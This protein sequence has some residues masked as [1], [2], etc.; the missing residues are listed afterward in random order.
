MSEAITILRHP[1]PVRQK[2]ALLSIASSDGYLTV[3]EG[4]VRSSKTVLA[5]MAF[6]LYVRSSPET[7]FLMSGRTMGTIEQNCILC[8]FGI[9]N[10]IP[11]ADYHLIGKKWG[12]TFRVKQSDGAVVS[13]VIIVQGASTIKDFMA[14]RGQ[15]YGGWFADEINMHDKEFV[16]EAFKRTAASNDRRHFFTLNP[17][18]PHEWIYTDYLDR[19]DAMTPDER[20][21]LGGYHWWHFTPEDNP[22]M[23]PA[24]LDALKMQYP[25]DSYL[26]RRYILG[27][28]C[29]AEG[30]IYPKVNMSYFRDF[31]PKDVDVRYASIDFGA[32]HATVMMFGGMFKGN[33]MDWRI[34]AEYYDQGSDKTTYDHYLGFLD[35]CGKLGVD[36]NRIVIAIDPAA[37]VLRLEFAKHG[38]HVIKAKNDVLP[39]IDFTRS[40]IYRG[41]LTFHS[42]M[43]HLLQEFGTYSWDPKASERGEEKPIK[44]GDD[45]VDTARYFAYTHIRPMI[46][47]LR[48]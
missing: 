25:A 41:Y 34:V 1:D 44:Q 43:K 35:M 7:R 47:G 8:E 13:K 10:M 32:E 36:P 23:T 16:V 4:A 24:K 2:K 28:R 39:G 30:L 9:L 40:L 33:H 5:L 38:L 11:G 22:I 42:S 17:G 46:G 27:E 45:C 12:I 18:G 6:S 48:D 19:Y 20:K 3:W 15:G 37:K 31:D 29:V 14:L 21:K 26:Y